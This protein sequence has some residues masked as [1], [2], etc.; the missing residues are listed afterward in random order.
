MVHETL[1]PV[2][3]RVRIRHIHDFLTLHSAEATVLGPGDV[4]GL[5]RIRLDQ[6]AHCQLEADDPHDVQE[7]AEAVENLEILRP[8]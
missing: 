5:V 1:I 2:G 3:T 7:L 6:P 4:P 8:M